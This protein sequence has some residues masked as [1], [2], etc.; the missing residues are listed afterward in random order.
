M[1]KYIA[2]KTKVKMTRSTQFVTTREMKCAGMSR[3]FELSR[4]KTARSLPKSPRL[5]IETSRASAVWTF[6][7]PCTCHCGVWVTRLS[8]RPS[9]SAP[10]ASAARKMKRCRVP[11][12]HATVWRLM[13]T[14]NCPAK[15]GIFLL[16]PLSEKGA[17][18]SVCSRSSSDKSSELELS[19]SA[20]G[21]CS[22]C[23]AAAPTPANDEAEEVV[24][25]VSSCSSCIALSLETTPRRPLRYSTNCVFVTASACVPAMR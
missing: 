8:C 1:Q 14:R 15:P 21:S 19:G 11:R 17:R 23:P 10:A 24:P 6:R 12:H 20:V 2:L 5:K 9:T 22:S 7:M 25:D 13:S 16:S 18:A 3:P 4:Q